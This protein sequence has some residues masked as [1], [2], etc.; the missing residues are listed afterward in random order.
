MLFSFLFLDWDC[1]F[2]P[3]EIAKQIWKVPQIPCWDLLY[4]FFKYYSEHS[5][6]KHLVLCPVIGEAI[7]KAKFV[8]I[9]MNN[10]DILGFYKKKNCD[11][12]RSTKIMG[13][14]FGE[15]LAVQDP[16]DLFH[17]ITKVIIPRKLQIFSHLCKK[18]Y[19]VM[20]NGIQPYYA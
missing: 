20:H 12:Q 5:K 9:P 11:A 2:C 3:I 8:D 14:F 16:F 6:L 13:N 19:E 7:P 1:T 4:G 10:K 18:T 15:G 17:N